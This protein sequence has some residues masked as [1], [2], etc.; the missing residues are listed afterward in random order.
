MR[1][2]GQAVGGGHTPEV[3]E[4]RIFLETLLADTARVL[5][6]AIK[7]QTNTEDS[8]KHGNPHYPP[9]TASR[10]NLIHMYDFFNTQ[11]IK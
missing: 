1:V 3:V 7:F 10:K 11:K 5:F 8:V 2:A 6:A 4:G 9:P